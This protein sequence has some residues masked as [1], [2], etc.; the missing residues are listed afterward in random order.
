[1]TQLGNRF[2]AL[3]RQL[4]LPP[5]PITFQHLPDRGLALG[6]GREHQH[7]AGILSF[8]RR[9][10]AFALLLSERESALRPLGRLLTLADAAQAPRDELVPSPHP[11]P[12]FR[13]FSG[14]PQGLDL[15]QKWK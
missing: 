14:P 7:I 8:L 9:A 6:Q 5:E 10:L 4:D 15:L 1:M 11:H 2:Q 3:E 12:P 13:R